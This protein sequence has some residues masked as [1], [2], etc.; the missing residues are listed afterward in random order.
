MSSKVMQCNVW[1]YLFKLA[2]ISCIS[3]SQN[4]FALPSTRII[5]SIAISFLHITFYPCRIVKQSTENQSK[6][7]HACRIR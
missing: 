2:E 3:T 5:T 7:S 1:A 6:A 4:S